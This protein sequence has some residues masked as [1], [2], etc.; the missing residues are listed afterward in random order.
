M[1]FDIEQFTYEG[2]NDH[3]VHILTDDVTYTVLFILRDSFT[4]IISM[5]SMDNEDKTLHTHWKESDAQ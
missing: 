1:H 5:E 4:S 2:F 3:G